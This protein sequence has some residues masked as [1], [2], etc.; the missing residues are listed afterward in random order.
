MFFM[1]MSTIEKGKMESASV[2]C[3]YF[4]GLHLGKVLEVV[5]YELI[6]CLL[7]PLIVKVWFEGLTYIVGITT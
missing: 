7:E 3:Q 1:L 4:L 2:G 5:S 6:G